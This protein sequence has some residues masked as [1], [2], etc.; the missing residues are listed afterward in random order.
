MSDPFMEAFQ[1]NFL[2]AQVLQLPSLVNSRNG[3]CPFD[4]KALLQAW[5]LLFR[6]CSFSWSQ[7]F[8]SIVYP[9][10]EICAKQHIR[11]SEQSR[12]STLKWGG[13]IWNPWVIPWELPSLHSQKG[14]L[15]PQP[16][17]CCLFTAMM[18][19]NPLSL[20][21][22]VGGCLLGLEWHLR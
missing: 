2:T 6:W 12:N 19:S 4:T 18:S 21:N 8:S 5:V 1:G 11:S 14:S 15:K 13:G 16:I 7:H 22:G 3:H 9:P 20:T 10:A 17:R